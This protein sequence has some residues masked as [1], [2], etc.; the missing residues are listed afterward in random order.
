MPVAS[1]PAESGELVLASYAEGRGTALAELA[2]RSGL[3]VT[4]ADGS[5][6]AIPIGAVPVVLDDDEIA[7]RG[8][9]ATPL[10]SATAKAARWRMTGARRSAVLE[11][12]GP[13]ERRLVQA[14]WPALRELAVTRVD[15]LAA[16]DPWALEVNTTIPAMQGYSDIAAES[17][18]RTFA[19]GR[20]DLP[21]LIAANG[22]NA[23]AL[24]DALTNLYTRARPDELASVGLL[25][26]RHDAQLT[27]LQYLA[28]RFRRAGL[29][30][31]VVH[32][33]ELTLRRGFLHHRGRPLQ[34]VYRHLFV[35]RLDGE[36]A[37]DVE[38][39]MAAAESTGTLILNPPAPHLE[40]KSTLALLSEAVESPELADS[41]GLDAA[42]CR[43]IAACVPWT[44]TLTMDTSG[45]AV[46]GS[47][48]LFE[49]VCAQPDEHVLKRSWSHGGDD[50]FVGRARDTQAFRARLHA[51]H[52][53]AGD[54]AGLCRHAASDT[55]GG[56]FVVQHAVP[57]VLAEQVLCTPDT[58]QRAQVVTDYAAYASLGVAPAWSGACRAAAS[59]IVNIAGGGGVV[60]VIRKRV[61]DRLMPGAPP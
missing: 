59:D 2:F 8:A 61:I 34:M 46:A 48:E 12:L 29:D 26:R 28:G 27:E 38:A 50:V 4:R 42:E 44:R 35:S 25:C 20:K 49:R 53:G 11:S 13:A 52:A 58:L 45:P 54:W 6:A 33:D 47:R 31:C 30:A 3:A 36:P 14:T 57:R 51:L 23:D 7:R 40:M 43:G 21:E 16:P 5:L 15:F 9:L 17:W 60:P 32:P 22:S 18:L 37:P 24:R 1:H 56:G 41:I 19:A 10:V 55:R 39:A